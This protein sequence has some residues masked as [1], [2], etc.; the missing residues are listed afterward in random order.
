MAADQ[1]QEIFTPD[2]IRV[3]DLAVSTAED[4]VCNYYKMSTSEWIR[5]RYDVRTLADLGRHEIVNG[6][7]AQIIRYKGQKNNAALSSASFDFYKM[8]LQ[9][10]SILS[11]LRN[12]RALRLLPFSL[13][14]VTH[15]LIHIVR[16]GKF[17]QN[18]DASPEEKIVEEARVHRITHDI[19]SCVRQP[20]IGEVF[21]FYRN[22]RLPLE[23]LGSYQ[24]E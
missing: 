15:E 23:E 4:L 8:C 13:Y 1:K 18:F 5:T 16:F 22:W 19:L 12:S 7:F 20:G 17:L 11:A 3:V 24:P 14:I 2:Q 10:H 9:D 21:E 6:P